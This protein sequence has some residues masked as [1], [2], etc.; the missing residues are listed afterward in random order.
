[1]KEKTM[2][3]TRDELRDLYIALITAKRGNQ[4]TNAVND[5]TKLQNKIKPHLSEDDR[6]AM[7]FMEMFC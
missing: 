6:R 5:F 3:F 1:M 7:E 4:N 2:T